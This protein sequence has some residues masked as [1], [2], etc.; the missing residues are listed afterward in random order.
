MQAARLSADS[1]AATLA[2]TLPQQAR[3]VV[4]DQAPVEFELLPGEL[5]AL[6][7]MTEVRRREFTSGR[8]C[9][10]AALAALG[11]PAEPVPKASTREPVWPPGIVGS[12]SHA[13]GLA[14]AAVGYSLQMTGLGIDLETDEPLDRKLVAMICRPE[15]RA[16]L[17][18][19]SDPSSMAKVMFSA[20]ESTYKCIWPEVRQ[21]V[22]FQDVRVSLD[23][24]AGTFKAFARSN[25]LPEDA[26]AGLV[27]H[28]FRQGGLL[29][30]SACIPTP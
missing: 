5:P 30:T 29:V 23:P 27:G 12:I 3:V 10:R 26:L 25:S 4:A 6:T 1:L 15:E 19:K 18:E 14:A 20:K 28:F 17:S 9:A 24:G 13:A 2:A 8:Y 16:W 21:F 22:D 11:L 7:G